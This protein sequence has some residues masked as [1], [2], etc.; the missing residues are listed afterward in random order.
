MNRN[1]HLPPLTD[2]D[3]WAEYE[4]RQFT[5]VGLAPV[6]NAGLA[7]SVQ[8]VEL[9]AAKCRVKVPPVEGM[10]AVVSEIA[11]DSQTRW[12]R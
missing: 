2:P 8:L 5:R 1:V 6:Q 7:S 12:R 11:P 10:V 3:T 9:V 4:P